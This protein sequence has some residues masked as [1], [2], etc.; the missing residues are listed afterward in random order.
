MGHGVDEKLFDWSRCKTGG[1]EFEK[2]K[3]TENGMSL[4]IE[5]NDCNENAAL[6]HLQD[7]E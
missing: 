6:T 4:I 7:K 2:I 5:R 3:S 1:N